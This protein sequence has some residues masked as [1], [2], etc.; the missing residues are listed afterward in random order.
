VGAIA[1]NGVTKGALGL[2]GIAFAHGPARSLGPALA[3]TGYLSKAWIY[4]LGPIAGA[5][6]AALLW[7]HFLEHRT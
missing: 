2:T 3:G 6:I 1:A 4:W 7:L 5:V